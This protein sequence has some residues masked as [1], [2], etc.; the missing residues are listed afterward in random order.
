M[1]IALFCAALVAA[2]ISAFAGYYWGKKD[3]T[4]QQT[5]ES[6]KTLMVLGYPDQDAMIQAVKC[7]GADSIAAY[8]YNT[9]REA[10]T[11]AEAIKGL[12]AGIADLECVIREWDELHG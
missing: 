11:P 4:K 12:R 8:V 10:N 2:I 3:M 1:N 5:D 6:W 7:N 9:V